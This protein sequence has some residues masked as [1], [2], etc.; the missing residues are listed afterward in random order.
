MNRKT[1]RVCKKLTHE[2]K[3]KPIVNN[4]Q[5]PI[6]SDECF[7]IYKKYWE[8]ENNFPNNVINHINIKP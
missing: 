8:D 2:I 4:R 5:F 6:C 3:Y 1:C 7:K